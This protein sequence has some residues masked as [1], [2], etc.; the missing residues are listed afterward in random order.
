MFN[1]GINMADNQLNA[2]A[3]RE[4]APTGDLASG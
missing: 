1:T 3:V 2:A 4:Y